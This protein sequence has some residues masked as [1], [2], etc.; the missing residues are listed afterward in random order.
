MGSDALGAVGMPRRWLPGSV[1]FAA[2]DAADII[3]RKH[4]FPLYLES[5]TLS[6]RIGDGAVA[7]LAAE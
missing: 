7:G 6:R 1:E 4:A 2:T 5:T 3:G